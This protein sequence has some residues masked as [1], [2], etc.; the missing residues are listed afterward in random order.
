MNTPLLVAGSIFILLAVLIHVLIFVM[1]SIAW[2]RPEIWKRFGV[3]TQED[4][5][6]MRPMAFNQGFYNL[7]LA[8]GAAVGLVLIGTGDLAQAG[9]GIALFAALT[10]VLAA[11]VLITSNPRLA[12]AA[13]IQGAA[14][15]IGSI[16]MVLAVT[17]G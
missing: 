12:R 1:E 4:S 11:L 13:L 9:V 17:T 6:V 3:R 15:L 2:S 16:L 10:M 14:P 5:E 7:F 8:L